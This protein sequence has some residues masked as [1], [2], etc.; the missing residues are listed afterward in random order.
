[1]WHLERQLELNGLDATDELQINTV[2]QQATQQNSEMPKTTCH[3]CIKPGHYRNHC[4]QLK[5]KKDQTRNHTNSAD[6]KTFEMVVVKQTLTPTIKFSTITTHTI[7]I[8][9]KTDDLDLSTHPVRPVVKLTI[10]QRNFILEQTQRTNR[11]REID[12]RKDKAKS[13]KEMVKAT[14]MGMSKLQ[15]KL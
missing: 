2:T 3:H 14:Q 6:K 11:L 13:N 4:R 10:P 9:K 12:D 8:R 5:R 7:Q 1:M 15:H